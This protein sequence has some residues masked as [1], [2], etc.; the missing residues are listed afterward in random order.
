MHE[1]LLEYLQERWKDLHII[2]EQN[3]KMNEDTTKLAR[4]LVNLQEYL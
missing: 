1:D 3:A 2:R 4:I